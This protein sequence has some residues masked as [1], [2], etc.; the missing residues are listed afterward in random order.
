MNYAFTAL[1]ASGMIDLEAVLF[2]GVCVMVFFFGICIGSFLNVCIYF[3]SVLGG[4]S[5]WAVLQLL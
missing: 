5:L 4:G 1:A 3:W 2:V